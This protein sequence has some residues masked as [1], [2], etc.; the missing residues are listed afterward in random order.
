MTI[1]TTTDE[2][3]EA[4]LRADDQDVL[5]LI[6]ATDGRYQLTVALQSARLS[7]RGRC[8]RGRDGRDP[9]ITP[10]RRRRREGNCGQTRQVLGKLAVPTVVSPV[11]ATHQLSI[12]T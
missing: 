7:T 9:A 4:Q 12:V 3:F 11:S 8:S 6:D 1:Q 10:W 2:T 5:W